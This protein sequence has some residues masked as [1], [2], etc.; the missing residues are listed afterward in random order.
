MFEYICLFDRQ[1]NPKMLDNLDNTTPIVSAPVV[2][3][4]DLSSKYGAR[5]LKR[6]IQTMIEDP[7]S[8]KLRSQDR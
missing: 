8:E 5:P 6:A 3:Y 7:L 2:D 1:S 4:E